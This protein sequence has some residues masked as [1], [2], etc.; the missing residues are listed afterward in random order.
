MGLGPAGALYAPGLITGRRKEVVRVLCHWREFLKALGIRMR[1]P[2]APPVAE[3]P[4]LK[5]V[6]GLPQN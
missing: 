2:F 5:A 3:L 4:A 6:K 1:V